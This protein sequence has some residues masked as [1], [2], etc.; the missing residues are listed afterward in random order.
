MTVNI[1]NEEL[2]DRVELK[3]KDKVAKG[4]VFS[5]IQFFIEPPIEHTPGDDDSSRVTFWFSDNYRCDMLRR[6]FRKALEL[7][8]DP[9][10]NK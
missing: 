7:L 9:A 4:V 5:G 2:T 8:D 6:A 1:Y 10:C 3:Q